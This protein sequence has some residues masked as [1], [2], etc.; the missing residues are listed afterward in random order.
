[1]FDVVSPIVRPVMRAM[2][3]HSARASSNVPVP[4]D[5][6]TCHAPGAD[7]DRILVFGTSA[8]IAAGVLSFDLGLPGQLAREL[9]RHTGRGV[10]VDVHA[11]SA[12]TVETAVPA[13]V[14]LSLWRYDAIVVVLG[15]A[16]ALLYTAVAVWRRE[17][18]M[19]L[20]VL[21][22]ESSSATSLVVAG[23]PRW[24]ASRG[25]AE[26]SAAWA[27]GRRCASTPRA[28]RPARGVRRRSWRCPPSVP[29]LTATGRPTTTS[30]GPASSLHRWR[31]TWPAPT[32][33]STRRWVRTARAAPPP[34]TGRTTS[35]T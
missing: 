6:P 26:W 4:T 27:T 23:I 19:L 18:A 12:L 10:D 2:F 16:D 15:G 11:T 22:L 29:V 13:A 28:R 33:S 35:S 20:E 25:S 30:R 24:P 17:L 1:M 5:A 7:T 9:S 8:T 14:G 34:S 31:A 21:R 32:R 3:R